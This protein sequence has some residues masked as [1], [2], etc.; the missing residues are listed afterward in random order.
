MTSQKTKTILFTIL[1]VVPLS[2]LFKYFFPETNR[3]T[4][5]LLIIFLIIVFHLI[6]NFLFSKK[7]KVD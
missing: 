5:F 2:F 4:A 3:L 6:G 7:K 1:F